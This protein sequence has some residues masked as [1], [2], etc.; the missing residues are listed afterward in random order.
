MAR[1]LK[2]IVVGSG[3][4]ADVRIVKNLPSHRDLHPRTRSEPDRFWYALRVQLPAGDEH[5]LLLTQVEMARAIKRARHNP[6]DVPR[7]GIVRKLLD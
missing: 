3:R 2:H 6:E 1:N 5:D 7:Q 4:I